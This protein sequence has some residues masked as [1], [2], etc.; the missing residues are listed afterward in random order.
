MDGIVGHLLSIVNTA[1][2][3]TGLCIARVCGEYLT[4]AVGCFVDSTLLE[5]RIGLGCVGK[6]NV[7]AQKEENPECKMYT[8][9]RS[10]DEHN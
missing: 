1:E 3:L 9:R 4:K 7:S 2:K 6:E 5:E 8:G 10:R